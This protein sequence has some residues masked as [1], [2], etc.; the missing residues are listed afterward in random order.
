M[1]IPI[2]ES[3]KTPYEK[4]KVFFTLGYEH[5]MKAKSCSGCVSGCS[6]GNLSLELSTQDE[7]IRKKI[8]TIFDEWSYYIE[9][10]IQE[11][12]G[13]GEISAYINVRESAQALIALAEGILL[14]CKTYNDPELIKK[15]TDNLFEMITI[16]RK[17]FKH[18]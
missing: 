10:T 9:K 2:F 5:Q 13:R 18:Y 3:D 8:E 15:I 11:A 12:I 4:L 16:R 14:L 6:F 1:I 7:M 17:K